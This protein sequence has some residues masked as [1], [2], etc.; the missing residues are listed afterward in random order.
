LGLVDGLGSSSYVARE[1][2]G[3]ETLV[4]YTKRR[5]FLEGL[6]E[7]LGTTAAN[8]FLGVFVQ[9]GSASLR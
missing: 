7:R 8:A 6:A 2:I 9:A 5:S 1:L 4:D 3:A